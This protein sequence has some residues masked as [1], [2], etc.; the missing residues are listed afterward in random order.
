MSFRCADQERHPILKVKIYKRKVPRMILRQ[1]HSLRVL[2]SRNLQMYQLARRHPI[3][4]WISSLRSNY[5]VTKMLI[6]KLSKYS[7][8][9]FLNNKS[10]IR[11]C[12]KIF[13][14]RR[15]M[16]L[17]LFQMMNRVWKRI[18]VKIK[19]LFLQ[20]G[21]FSKNLRKVMEKED[22]LQTKTHNKK[23]KDYQKNWVKWMVGQQVIKSTIIVNW[24]KKKDK[25][26]K[27]QNLNIWK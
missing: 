17:L 2:D 6:L 4:Q 5:T 8:F 7:S 10:P 16:T 19:I 3:V 20:E 14:N 25:R 12:F 24:A 18:C 26:I 15:N 23:K 13:L 11:K 22:K 1:I 21:Q 9:Q 27:L